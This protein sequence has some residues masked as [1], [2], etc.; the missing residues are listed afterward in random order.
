MSPDIGARSLGQ[1][2]R[3][4]I[5]P[6]KKKRTFT[7]NLLPYKDLDDENDEAN[8]TR[9]SLKQKAKEFFSRFKKGPKTPKTKKLKTIDVNKLSRS[10][11]R[12]SIDFT[13]YGIS[14]IK[15]SKTIRLP[16][17]VFPTMNKNNDN[18]RQTVKAKSEDRKY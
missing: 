8:Q 16:K 17:K 10:L 7:E 9:K 6:L 3:R 4:R 15:Q 1:P 13:G 2:S 18:L 5:N 12:P 11:P 14:S